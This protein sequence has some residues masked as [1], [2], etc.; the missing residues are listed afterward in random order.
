ML[1][2]WETYESQQ[3]QIAWSRKLFRAVSYR[4]CRNATAFKIIWH[5]NGS[6]YVVSHK[7]DEFEISRGLLLSRRTNSNTTAIL[8]NCNKIH[9]FVLLN[10]VI[11]MFIPLSSSP[12]L[13]AGNSSATIQ[14]VTVQQSLSSRK[15]L[16][17]CSFCIFCDDICSIART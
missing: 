4:N 17:S 15:T 9:M 14:F 13:S 5:Q 2:S 10:L 7:L 16:L 6:F 12:W 3:V 8:L 11:F 1:Y